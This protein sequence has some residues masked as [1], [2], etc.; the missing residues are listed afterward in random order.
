VTT[1]A[2]RPLV[3][4]DLPWLAHTGYWQR[5]DHAER[6]RA[7]RLMG[8]LINELCLA[9]ERGLVGVGLRAALDAPAL[10]REPGLRERLTA[11]LAD[12]ER[13]A[14]WFA[15]YNHA[16]DPALY[17]ADGFALIAAPIA[18]RRFGVSVARAPGAWRAAAWLA[19]A[20]EE[21]CCELARV[22]A[23]APCGELGERDAAYLHLHT[24][25]AREEMA[26]VDLDAE[27]LAAA[28]RGLPP[29]GRALLVRFARAA[30]GA[31][32]RPRRGA[33]RMIARFIEEF[34][35]WR[36]ER[37][38]MTRSVIAVGG[39]PAYWRSR[40]VGGGLPR[41]TAAAA[42]WGASWPVAIGGAGG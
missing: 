1:T 2:E 27:L 14:R 4:E 21:W 39:D 37:A 25:H 29:F 19:L 3:P 6:L 8:Q 35:R 31:L 5:F 33:A 23:D 30:L 15:A 13:H 7:N 22:L 28:S 10:A 17:G 18:L 20:T 40:G 11:M 24:A 12:E 9:L 42:A 32:M 38:A 26:H 34:P 16:V 36:G 41:T